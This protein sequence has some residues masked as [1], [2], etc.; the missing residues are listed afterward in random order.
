[1]THD[2]DL[3]QAIEDLHHVVARIRQLES[4]VADA[5]NDPL[6]YSRLSAAQQDRADQLDLVRARAER[7]NLHPR[8]LMLI[9]EEYWRLKGPGKRKP[10][11]GAIEVALDAVLKQAKVAEAEAIAEAEFAR[12]TSLRA[13]SRWTAAAEALKY[14]RAA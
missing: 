12:M 2:P 14:V 7:L 3:M 6:K 1:V 11:T 9:V 10:T 8:A 4:Q 13:A 5:I